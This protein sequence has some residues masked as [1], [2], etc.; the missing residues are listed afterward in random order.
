MPPERQWLPHELA[1]VLRQRG[2]RGGVPGVRGV[3][4]PP[5][6]HDLDPARAPPPM[7]QRAH[8]LLEGYGIKRGDDV[9]LVVKAGP[10]PRTMEDFKRRPVGVG[11][12]VAT[13]PAPHSPLGR[14]SRVLASL[15][16]WVWRVLHVYQQGEP[17]AANTRGAAVTDTITYEAQLYAPQ[18]AVPGNKAPYLPCWDAV[19]LKVFL[20]TEAE[21]ECRRQ[22]RE[23]KKHRF[24]KD[25][26]KKVKKETKE[27]G[28]RGEEQEQEGGAQP[29][30]KEGE[31]VRQPLTALLRPGNTLGGGFFLTGT[32]RLPK[33]I[34]NFILQELSSRAAGS[35]GLPRA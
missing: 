18:A 2:L 6:F 25:K 17:L 5:E 20:L 34:Q 26:K 15:E 4:A 22:K 19:P 30:S 23:V 32:S 12:F 8:A 29:S 16:F 13:R 27:K 24:K 11:S 35:S 9:A 1:E 7:L 10:P 3:Q 21:K 14:A 28:N 31:M 33:L